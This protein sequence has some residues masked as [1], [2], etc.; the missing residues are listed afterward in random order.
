M[1][2]G[3]SL[4]GVRP[5]LVLLL[6]GAFGFNAVCSDMALRSENV[7]VPVVSHFRDPKTY[8]KAYRPPALLPGAIGFEASCF[9]SLGLS[10]LEGSDSTYPLAL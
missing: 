6:L 9:R 5:P 7:L 1:T 3:L 8:W 2:T 10:F 4:T